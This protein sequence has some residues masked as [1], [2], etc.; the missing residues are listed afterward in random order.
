M[1]PIVGP[2]EQF[3]LPDGAKAPLFVVKFDADGLCTTPKTKT[4]L[5][6]AIQGGAFTDLYLLSH[7]WNTTPKS[8]IATYREWTA[9]LLD[10][11]QAHPIGRKYRPAFV[12]VVWP[13]VWIVPWWERGPQ[14]G[15]AGADVED[16]RDDAMILELARYVGEADRER[17]YALTQAERLDDD[18]AREFITLLGRLHGH[19]DD[20]VGEDDGPAVDALLASWDRIAQSSGPSPFVPDD[21]E[22]PAVIRPGGDNEPEAAG[23]VGRAPLDAIRLF[24]V[25]QMKDRAATVGGKGVAA[26]LRDLL[27]ASGERPDRAAVRFHLVGHSFGAKVMLSAICSG[28][29]PDRPVNSLLLL[30]PAINQYGL[31]DAGQ[32]PQ[33]AQPGGYNTALTRVAQPILSTFTNKDAPLRLFFHIALQRDRDLGEL[34]IAGDEPPSIYAAMG[35]YG[36]RGVASMGTIDIPAPGTDYPLGPGE[37]EVYALRAHSVILGHGDVGKPATYWALHA[38]VRAS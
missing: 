10:Q 15:A 19:G 8:A 17:F 5:I 4:S 24:S 30:Q 25:F 9:G 33:R 29:E 6:D 13:S 35:G 12:G 36:P 23:A 7:G 11:A 21:E 3:D 2:I 26:L 31:A 38:L 1:T 18:E 34:R 27:A 32:V 20:D 28:P 14:I 37:P 16:E 22:E